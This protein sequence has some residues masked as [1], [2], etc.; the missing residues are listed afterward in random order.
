MQTEMTRKHGARV[1]I[2]VSDEICFKTKTMTKD[3]DGHYIIIK[4]SIQEE[5]ITLVNI[6]AGQH[7]ST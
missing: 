7:R 2:L 6:Y 4:G 5:I 3:K 1:A